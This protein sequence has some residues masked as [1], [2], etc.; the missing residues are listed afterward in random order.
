MRGTQ[1]RPQ[2]RC[3]LHAL[4][5]LVTVP[6]PEVQCVLKLEEASDII[7]SKLQ[8]TQ[9]LAWLASP[10]PPPPTGAMVPM[11]PGHQSKSPGHW[12]ARAALLPS[13]PKQVLNDQLL[14]EIITG[15]E[16]RPRTQMAFKPR[17]GY[18]SSREAPEPQFLYR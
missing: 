10:A 17:L 13:L 6:F 12:H 8:V 11:G 16:H 7:S 9:A 15:K 3:L 14:V 4:G 5:T 1:S 18:L 2:S